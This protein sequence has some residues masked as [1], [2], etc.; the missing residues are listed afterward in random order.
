MKVVLETERLRLREYIPEDFPWLYEI[1]SDKVT[2][3]HY[4]K[5]YDQEG[6]WRWLYWSMNNYKVY[7]FGLWAIE[8]KATGECIGDCGITMQNI[9]GESLPELGYHIAK[10]HWRQGYGKEAAKAVRDWFFENTD[11]P[12]L[13]SY[14]THT[15]L[16]SYSTAASVGLRKIKEYVDTDGLCF[17]YALKREDYLCSSQG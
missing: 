1:L 6:T 17:V 8:I 11:F 9:D 12:A 3:Q 7:G 14:M 10:D 13:Y 16:P 15:N 2:M 5:P 4:P